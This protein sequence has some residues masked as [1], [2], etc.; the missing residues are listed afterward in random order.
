MPQNPKSKI[1]YLLKYLLEKTD[2]E[3]T[4]STTD[5]ID[6]LESQGISVHRKTIPLDIELLQEF[7][8]DVITVKSRQNR[9][10]V[11]S[12]WF[13]QPELK[14]LVDAV[15][16]SKFITQKKSAELIKKLTSFTSEHR[17]K[18]L[19]RQLYINKRVKPEN[20]EIYY[21]VD[22]IH[23]AIN[24]KM[25][26]AFKYYEYTQK[27]QKIKKHNSYE[28]NLSPYALSWND[29]HYYVFGFSPKHDK[30]VKFRVDRMTKPKILNNGIKP[31]PSDFDITDF[32]RQVFDMYDGE[33]QTVELK[34][35]NNL[36]KVMIDRFG[37]SVETEIIDDEYFKATVDVTITPT[38]YA[39]IFKF[40]GNIK[41][42]SPFNIIDKYREMV[43][44]IYLNI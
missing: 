21:I 10:F 39:W 4:V 34:C 32:C 41:I 5:I 16:S 36:M 23:E 22:T 31:I 43:E 15:A 42:L 35:R 11:G 26:I 44:K 28:Y 33:S 18:S 38:F 6:H 3:H 12:R 37:E 2:D 30:I 24:T 40:A 27:K 17:G 25:Q 19:D 29:N 20:E 1:L 13:E 14:L 9:Y 8:I 7:G